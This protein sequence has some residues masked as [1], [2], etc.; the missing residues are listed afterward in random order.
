MK[1]SDNICSGWRQSRLLEYLYQSTPC[2][3]LEAPQMLQV[4]HGSFQ[5]AKDIGR[6][7]LEPLLRGLPVDH[8][9]DVFDVGSFAIEIL[10]ITQVSTA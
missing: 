9:P 8:V 7:S 5:D 6:G 3:N 4:L 1:A 10:N 2:L